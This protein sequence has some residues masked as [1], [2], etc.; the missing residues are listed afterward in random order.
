[1]LTQDEIDARK[2]ARY[3]K[4]KDVFPGE[5]KE[6][7]AQR[8][9]YLEHDW[10]DYGF[11]DVEKENTRRFYYR[12]YNRKEWIDK[13]CYLMKIGHSNIFHSCMCSFAFL[14]MF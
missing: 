7:I 4:S 8:M 14:H 10:T 9:R 5:S 3:P 6:E 1:M 13:F 12:G 11:S 2:N